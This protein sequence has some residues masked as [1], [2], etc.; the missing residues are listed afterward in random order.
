MEKWKHIMIDY[1]MQLERIDE[2]KFHHY[3]D[4]IFC[5]LAFC[6]LLRLIQREI[7]TGFDP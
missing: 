2:L 3:H 1:S 4:L 5:D 6:A 7:G